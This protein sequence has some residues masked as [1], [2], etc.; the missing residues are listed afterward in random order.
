[1]ILGWQC[2]FYFPIFRN[3]TSRCRPVK[4]GATL[5]SSQWNLYEMR[6]NYWQ[7]VAWISPKST[8]ENCFMMY[9]TIV[10][11]KQTCF[12]GWKWTCLCGKM[13][14]V[15][16]KL[17]RLLSSFEEII[18]S[19]LSLCLHRYVTY[20]FPRITR[21]DAWGIFKWE[22]FRPSP[23]PLTAHMKKGIT[24]R[25]DVVARFFSFMAHCIDL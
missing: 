20:A 1:M 10:W 21:Y 16:S 11:R 12:R 18:M 22:F 4:W 23:S 6:P 19:P 5:A 14:G 13:P 7:K 25:R 17:A 8:I 9:P 15:T 2:D 3:K 24:R